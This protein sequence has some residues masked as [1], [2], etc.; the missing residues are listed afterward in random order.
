M[1]PTIPN[2]RPISPVSRRWF[3]E[4]CGVGVG[5]L[6]LGAL[7]AGDNAAHAATTGEHPLAVRPPHYAPRAKRVIYLFQAGAPSHL[8]LYDYKPELADWSGKKP[9]AE[10]LE[11]YRAA[12]IKPDSAL[13]GP[14]YDFAR[15]GES[16]IEI[17]NLLPYT[18]SIVDK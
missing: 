7:A 12:F 6:A 14:K 1:K 11:G 10:L 18:A 3:L 13:L 9:P 16:G 8:D 4:Q 2:I 15:H 5:S 17:S